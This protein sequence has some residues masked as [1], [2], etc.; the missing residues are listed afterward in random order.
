MKVAL[1]VFLHRY[2]LN[3]FETLIPRF[4]SESVFSTA[5]TRKSYK[6]RLTLGS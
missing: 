3:P 2:I 1:L 4:Y 6:M 5:A